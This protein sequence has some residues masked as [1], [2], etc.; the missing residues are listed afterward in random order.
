M[1]ICDKEHRYA[2]ILSDLPLDQGGEGRHL[3]AG[4]AYEAGLSDGLNNTKR[5]IEALNLPFS[6]AGTG[7]HKSPQAAYDKGF[8]KGLLDYKGL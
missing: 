8:K 1:T 5:S 4:C 7:R 3:C 6:Q 2:D